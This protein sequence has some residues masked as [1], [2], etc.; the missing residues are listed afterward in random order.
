MTQITRAYQEGVCSICKKETLVR[1]IVNN[2][3]AAMICKNCV[4][5][6]GSMTVNELLSKFGEDI[7]LNAS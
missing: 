3:R 5:G 1:V 2:K 7:S 6:I 4:E